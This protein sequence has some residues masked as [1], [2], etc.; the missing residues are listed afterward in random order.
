MV[1]TRRLQNLHFGRPWPGTNPSLSEM[2]SDNESFRDFAKTV[3]AAATNPAYRLVKMNGV[4]MFASTFSEP[5]RGG[6]RS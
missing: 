1:P 5:S 6:D 3:E 4:E 2:L